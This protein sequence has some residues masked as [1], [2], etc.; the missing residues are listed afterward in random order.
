MRK[1]ATPSSTIELSI[2]FYFDHFKLLKEC[3]IRTML[4]L[5]SVRI[6]DPI[7]LKLPCLHTPFEH[8]VQFFIGSTL[9]LWHPQE[10]PNQAWHRKTTEEEPQLSSH[11]RLIWVDKVRNS[12]CHDDANESLHR[13]RHCNS[14]R[15][16]TCCADLAENGESNRTDTPV[17]DRV[18]YQKPVIVSM[19]IAM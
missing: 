15:T 2:D 10:P 5:P 7:P 9:H 12:D 6:S 3:G 11:V 17:V 13:G 14:L 19:T 1:R 18:P 16:Y 4:E 8:D